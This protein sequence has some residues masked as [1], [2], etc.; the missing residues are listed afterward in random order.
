MVQIYRSSFQC[1]LFFPRSINSDI[2]TFIFLKLFLLIFF[3]VG[4]A[5]PM[6]PPNY[7]SMAPPTNPSF[8]RFSEMKTVLLLTVA[9]LAAVLGAK[10]YGFFGFPQFQDNLKHFLQPTPTEEVKSEAAAG[11]YGGR[12]SYGGGGYGNGGGYGYP[13]FGPGYWQPLIQD[14]EFVKIQIL[15]AIVIWQ[16]SAFAQTQL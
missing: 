11:R 1:F 6:F 12:P 14:R 15:R 4:G 8:D 2:S 7:K 5:H 3:S 16:Q 13:A 10:V 9:S